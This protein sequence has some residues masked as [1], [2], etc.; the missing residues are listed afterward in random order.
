M[1]GRDSETLAGI[2]Q[3]I[4]NGNIAFWHSSCQHNHNPASRHFYRLHI[5]SEAPKPRDSE[6]V[7]NAYFLTKYSTH[8]E[9]LAQAERLSQE[10]KQESM[11]LAHYANIQRILE[12]YKKTRI[13]VNGDFYTIFK[14]SSFYEKTAIR[15]KGA[16]KKYEYVGYVKNA[17]GHCSFSYIK[18]DKTGRKNL[19]VSENERYVINGVLKNLNEQI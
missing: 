5:D 9:E 14:D 19:S 6:K 10:R 12:H 18:P 17:S 15:T 4:Q 11:R 3:R 2:K 16:L 7:W 13:L 8:F 1:Y